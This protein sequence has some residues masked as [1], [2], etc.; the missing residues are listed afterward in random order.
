MENGA[1]SDVQPAPLVVGSAGSRR[2]L[3]GSGIFSRLGFAFGVAWLVILLSGIIPYLAFASGT[4][5]TYPL[6]AVFV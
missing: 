6:A 3:S 1:L 5:I 2:G 4:I